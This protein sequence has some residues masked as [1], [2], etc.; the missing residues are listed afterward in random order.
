MQ[1]IRN[2]IK[3]NWKV[4]LW[5]S[6]FIA[7][8]FWKYGR[9][10]APRALFAISFFYSLSMLTFMII[11]LAVG[12]LGIKKVK[13]Y[14][15]MAIVLPLSIATIFQIVYNQNILRLWYSGEFNRQYI[16][17]LVLLPGIFFIVGV[18]LRMLIKKN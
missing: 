16:L 14:L 2:I 12:Y 8:V 1:K 10:S 13:G 6:L 3:D 11:P 15:I 18:L 9:E 4:L 17:G 5:L 7:V